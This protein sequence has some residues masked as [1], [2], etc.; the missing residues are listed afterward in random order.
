[1]NIGIPRALI[2]GM[3]ALF[4]AYHLVLAAYSLLGNYAE[5]VAPIVLAMVAYAIATVASLVPLGS[6]RMPLWLAIVNVVVV[7]ALPLLVTSQLDPDREGGNGYATWYIA[8]VGTL[9]TIT[10]TRRRHLWAWIGVSFLVVQT[11]I[12][13]GFGALAGLGVIGSVVWVAVSHILSVAIWKATLDA[14]RFASAEREAAEWHAAQEA[15]LYERQFR[16]EQTSMMALPML[17]QIVRR[18]GALTPA[19][20]QECL[21]LEGAIRDEIRGRKLLNDSVREQV[22]AARRRGATVTLLDEGGIDDLSE[23]ELDVVLDQL[24]DALRD[25]TAER[26]IA[27]TVPEGSDVAVTVVGLSGGGGASVASAL[28]QEPDEDDEVALWLEIPRTPAP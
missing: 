17:E 19:E 28:G 1:M 11:V 15:H 20:R 14:R 9:M 13:S 2:V 21:H 18:G 26:V 24:A 22:M 5:S 10:S 23:S 7:I 8:A 4:S 3:G 25:T 6:R 16:L 12:W 27:R